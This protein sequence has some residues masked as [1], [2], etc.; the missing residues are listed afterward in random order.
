M[1]LDGKLR[2]KCKT[3]F[4]TVKKKKGD[5]PEDEG[6]V[7]EWAVFTASFSPDGRPAF[8]K[9]YPNKLTESTKPD[10]KYEVKFGCRK[11]P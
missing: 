1:F 6:F 10:K 11:N 9:L 4:K 3:C 2:T 8:C 5:G 7:L